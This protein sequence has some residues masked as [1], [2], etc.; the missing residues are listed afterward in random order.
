MILPVL[1]LCSGLYLARLIFFWRGALKRP[2]LSPATNDHLHVSVIVPARDEE[3]NLE[4]CLMALVSSDYPADKLEVIVVDDRSTDGTAAI[5]DDFAA[6]YPMI[7]ALHRTEADV[8]ANLKGKPGALQQGFDSAHGDV[9]LMTDADCLPHPSWVRSMT[10]PF[11]DPTVGMTAGMT[12]IRCISVL[13]HVQDVEW[14]YTQTMA[15]SGINNGVPLG[16]FGN[17][18]GIRA[19]LYKDLGGYGN[20]PFSV[21]E[22]LALLQTVHNAGWHVRYL[23][24]PMATV[25]TLPVST[26]GEYFR[27]RQRWARG[28][29]A[30]GGRAAL[31]VISSLAVWTGILVSIITAQWMWL[32]VFFALRIIGDSTLIAYSAVRLKRYGLLPWIVPSVSLLLLTEIMLPIL[33]TRRTVVWKNQVFRS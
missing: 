26:L 10:E 23:C 5:L 29:M 33:V 22:D 8:H 17:D 20:I 32:L 25:E 27:Q 3:Q 21:T 16:C 1:F 12:T 28:G 4:R 30:L 31:F 2:P 9:F 11:R 7:H 15:R 19:S 14:T 18:L 13:D 24:E 6:R